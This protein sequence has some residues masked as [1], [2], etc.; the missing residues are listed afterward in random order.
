MK[1]SI[2]RRTALKGLGTAIALPFLES[3]AV[4]APAAP[5]VAGAPKRLAF[6][7]VPNGVNMAA[8]T[9]A[10]EGKL[11][12]LTGILE[13]LNSFRDHINVI[14]GLTLDKARANGDGP[15]D[16]ARAMS[17][18]LTGRQARKTHGADI[19]AGISADQHVATVIGDKTRFPS[20]ELGIERGQQAGNCDSGYSCAY[21]SNLS[22]RGES[23]PNAKE[24]DPKAVFERLFG[25]VDPKE[26]AE[27][28]AKREL[29]N[30]SVLDFVMEDAKGL[31]A[32]LGSG[33]RKKL[34]EY[35]SSVRE[36]EQRIQKAREVSRAPVPKPNMA[37]PTGVPKDL[38]EHMRLMADLMVLSFQTDLTRVATLPFANEGSNKP[39]KMIDVPEGHHDLSHHGSDAT[40][41]AKI[42]KINTFH[43]EQF[44]YM[45]GKMKAVKEANGSCLLDNV[46]IVYGSGNGDGDRHNHDDLPILLAGRGGS[47]IESGRHIVFPKRANT[48]ITNLYLA[49]FERM[50]APASSFGDSTGVLKL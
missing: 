31:N 2:S 6:V 45:L 40:K 41:L 46:M 19:R 30:K 26:L 23:T 27:A 4:A 14:S 9:P 50:G 28:R 7:Y 47:T 12:E 18:F 15:G 44:A 38:Q 5:A 33:D 17:A 11:K 3:F 32:T 48:P 39:Y 8:W 36:V 43:M 25:G 35:L 22:W 1:K 24:C 21:S 10:A 29:Y 16:H 49:L 42:K 37:A 13:P 34:D 20:L